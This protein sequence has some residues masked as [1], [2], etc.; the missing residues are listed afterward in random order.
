MCGNSHAAWVLSLHEFSR[1]AQT[2]NGLIALV[3]VGAF[4]LA[5]STVLLGIL[6]LWAV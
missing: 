2:S 1:G 6:L 4:L 3:H 5:L